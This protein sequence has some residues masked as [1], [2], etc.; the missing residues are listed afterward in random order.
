MSEKK[1]PLVTTHLQGERYALTGMRWA[2]AFPEFVIAYCDEKS[3]PGL[4]AEPRVIG[5]FAGSREAIAAVVRTSSSGVADSKNT[6]E[7]AALW[8]EDAPRVPETPSHARYSLGL[9]EAG[10]IAYAGLQHVVIAAVLVLYSKSIIG[11][12]LRA[13]VGA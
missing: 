5:I 12:A 6:R 7:K 4:I 2:G 3:L 8:C 13:S 11:A 1:T 10:R 9:K